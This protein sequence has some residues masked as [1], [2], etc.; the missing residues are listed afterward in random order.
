MVARDGHHD[1]FGHRV[2][3]QDT[4]DFGDVVVA[5]GALGVFRQLF[6]R[7]IH[8]LVRER[9]SAAAGI[10]LR[11]RDVCDK[12]VPG[13]QAATRDADGATLKWVAVIG[14]LGRRSGS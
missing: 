7:S 12:L 6:A 5:V 4:L 9:V 10:G 1:L 14:F 13:S 2:H 3:L 11:T 8:Q